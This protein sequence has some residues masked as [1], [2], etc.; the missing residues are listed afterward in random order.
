[1]KALSAEEMLYVWEQ[2]L[3]QPLL[4]RVLILLVTAFPEIKPDSLVNLS[5]GQRDRY[6][7]QLR[8]SLFGQYLQNTAVCPQCDQRMEWESR[9]ADFV[10]QTAENSTTENK[11][12]LNADGFKLQFRLP[13]S[14][15]IA[16]VINIEN[17]EK[18]QL[19]LLSRCLLKVEHE[20]ESCDNSQLPDSII[21]QVIDEIEMLDPHADIHINLNCAE[22]S[23][24]W[25][26]LFDIDS[27]LWIEI[28]DWAEKML[29]TIHKIA[30]AYGWSEK[31]IL[32]LS[33]V[34]R[35]LYIGMLG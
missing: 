8:E 26:V 35:Q 5:V 15:D 12:E 22:C 7:L 13:N 17:N 23:H 9:I 21:Q 31:D 32:R 10:D 20:G 24:S 4:Q 1:M 18:A 29:Q 30:A 11:F 28:N 3:N 33:P 2:G 19:H 25:D 6:L 34:R 16:A 14:L 27:F